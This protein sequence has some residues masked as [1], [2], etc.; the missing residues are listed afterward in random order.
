MNQKLSPNQQKCYI[1]WEP[2]TI[3]Y[4]KDI[5]QDPLQASIEVLDVVEVL[6]PIFEPTS[7]DLR[8]GCVRKDDHKRKSKVYPPKIG[9][10]IL[11]SNLP[12]EAYIQREICADEMMAPH[13]EVPQLSKPVMIDWVKKALAQKC[14]DPEIY[15]LAWFSFDFRTVRTKIFAEELLEGQ[16]IMK[17]IHD[18]YGYYE[19]P[20][21]KKQGQ[22]WVYSPVA[23]LFLFPTFAILVNHDDWNRTMELKI[24]VGWSWWTQAG[25]K[26]REVLMNTI[27]QIEALGWNLEFFR[28]FRRALCS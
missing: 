8:V 6:Q 9:W 5:P 1:H 15:D 24:N 27:P 28:R 25:F 17:A 14:P 7:A 16:S 3:A 10:H 12:E 2:F 19:Y 23:D 4:E 21:V 13:F 22:L 20:L 11:A 26:E 18:R